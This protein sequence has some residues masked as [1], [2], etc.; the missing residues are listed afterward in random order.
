V[1]TK[2]SCSYEVIVCFPEEN[3][4]VCVAHFSHGSVARSQQAGALPAVW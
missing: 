2:V 1:S 3:F 4:A